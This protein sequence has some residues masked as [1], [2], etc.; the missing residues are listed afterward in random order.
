MD[1]KKEL[2]RISDIINDMPIEEFEE[3]LFECGLGR[4]RP[5]GESSL[6]KC[7]NENF[8]EI[9]MNYVFKGRVYLKENYQKFN[10][11]SFDGQEVA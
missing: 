4:I 3:M 5:S 1:F 7:V 11:F 9:N 2:K 6:V 10:D 8:F